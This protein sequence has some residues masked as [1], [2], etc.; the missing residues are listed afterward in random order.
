MWSNAA[1][2]SLSGRAT[3][4][5]PSS[6][7][8]A[9]R[10]RGKR[11]LSSSSR[12]RGLT[13][14]S[15]NSRTDFCS[16]SCS[17]VSSR[18][19]V[20]AYLSLSRYSS[21]TSSSGTS[22]V[23]ISPWSASSASSTPCTAS[24]SSVWPSS[25]SSPTLSESARSLMLMP[26]RSPMR[27][28]RALCSA[29]LK[30]NF[31]AR[32]GSSEL[33]VAPDDGSTPREARRVFGL[34]PAL[35]F[36]LPAP[37]LTRATFFLLPF[38]AVFLAALRFLAMVAKPLCGRPLHVTR[39]PAKTKSGQRFAQLLV[40]DRQLFRVYA[41]FAGNGHEVRIAHP[42]RQGMQMQMA[43]HAGAGS[44]AEVHAQV[45]A[46]RPVKIAKNRFHAL[47]QMHHFGQRCGSAVAEFRNVRVGNHHH[48]AGGIGVAIQ[49]HERGS[50][51][52]SD[53]GYLVILALRRVAE[54]AFRLLSGVC[55]R[56]VLIAPGCPEIVH[57]VRS[58]ARKF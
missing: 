3:P 20:W 13:S 17:S 23:R 41:R 1:P 24:A 4:V 25:S 15:A 12:V 47:R 9:N 37:R 42:A 16:S 55:L 32:R 22:R 52:V 53:E 5:K 48:M 27:R 30:R 44:P 45:H 57:C 46:V 56:D 49:D 43:H 10:S 19:T 11:P 54:N 33:E 2:P 36:S 21:G 38:F 31:P 39:K 7:A 8:M 51:A 50:S 40:A 14:D 18:F 34:G 26:C 35:P 28:R 58:L 29:S 6:A